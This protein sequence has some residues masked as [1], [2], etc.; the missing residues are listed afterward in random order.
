IP[1][2]AGRISLIASPSRVG[3]GQSAVVQAMLVPLRPR[4]TLPKKSP[5]QMLMR[6][7]TNI[8]CKLQ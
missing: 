2:A 5:M 4:Y 1:E 3:K 7:I 8:I 6:I